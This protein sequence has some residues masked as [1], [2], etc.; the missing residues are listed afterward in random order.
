MK[1]VQVI[2]EL[3]PAGAERIVSL[4]SRGLKKAG[5]EV[6]VISLKALPSNR[7]IVE[8]LERSGISVYSL[9]M[10][11]TTPYRVFRLKD[12]LEEIRP[13]VVHSH[14]FHA[15]I[16]SRFAACAGGRKYALIN[17]V[18][19]SE[20]RK[21]RRWYFWLDRLTFNMCDVH[22][23]V[24]SAT[25][26]Y[27]AL[28][29]GVSPGVIRVVH[30]GINPSAPLK[31]EDVERLKRE[32]NL[33]GFDKLIGMTGRL[34]RQK[35]FDIILDLLPEISLRVPEGEKWAI[36]ITGEGPEEKNLRGQAEALKRSNVEVI[37]LG[38][39]KNAAELSGIFDL[40]IMPSRYEGFGLVLAEA[41][42]QGAPILASDT[43]SLPELLEGYENGKLFPVSK[44]DIEMIVDAI[45]G[46]I[47]SGRVSPCLR[48]SVE[49]MLGAYIGIYEE[50]LNYGESG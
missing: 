15:N 47:N 21:N 11:R 10:T 5:H 6:S 18:H 3:K 50:S 36:V 25:A 49:K 27:H 39:R 1:I 37:F 17:T 12:I 4:L 19:I 9:E 16:A 46:K 28:K 33:E 35:G 20:R 29:L 32:L 31:K 2:T 14:L 38:Y 40:F 48:F 23:A 22:T 34:D 24:S 45:V 8:E 43:D 30:N 44:I 42:A 13:D 7:E 26:A 41:M